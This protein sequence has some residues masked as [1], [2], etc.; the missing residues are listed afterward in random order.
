MARR[1]HVLAVDDDPLSLELI[2]ELLGSG[3]EVSTAAD[4]EEAWS[5]LESSSSVDVV[6]ADRMM[7]RLGGLELLGRMKSHPRLRHLPVIIETAA[8]DRD[9][10]AE[11]IAAGATYYL[12]KPL[13]G[14]LLES[15]VRAASAD[16]ARVRELLAEVRSSADA[17]RLLRHGR[18]AYRTPAEA[19]GLGALLANS[20]PDPERVVVG[21]TELLVN[22]VEHGNLEVTYA[23][24]GEL[25]RTGRLREELEQRLA[26]P[27]LGARIATVELDCRD[28]AVVFTISDQGGGFD[29]TPFLKIDPARA[30]DPNGRGIA[31]ANLM[32]FDSLRY[33]DGGRVVEARLEE[34]AA[35]ATPGDAA[36]EAPDD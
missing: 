2:V 28:D 13:D 15:M 19:S 22:A 1:T 25:M 12:T 34:A 32:S 11:G 33:R 8:A 16:H 36:S 29:P 7:P 17:I 6:V 4:G 23:E 26:S 30:F 5:L 35:S 24:K 31:I 14:A 18:F 9:Q 21:L 3:Y 20:C 27:V 10:V